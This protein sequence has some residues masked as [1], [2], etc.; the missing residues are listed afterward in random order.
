MKKND[1]TR[2]MVTYMLTFAMAISV[3]PVNSFPSMAAEEGIAGK[4]VQAEESIEEREEETTEV[5]VE[6]LE[7]GEDGADNFEEATPGNP[8]PD[9][10]VQEIEEDIELTPTFDT[11][12][13]GVS[14]EGIDFSGCELLIASE[15]TDIFTADTD[16]VSE[17]NGIYLTRYSNPVQTR[18]AYT[19]YYTRAS[20]VEVNGE[21]KVSSEEVVE[22]IGEAEENS[23]EDGDV[24]LEEDHGEA[25]L[26]DINMGTDAFSRINGTAVPDCKGYIALIDSGS[27]ETGAV[28]RA[29]SLIDDNSNDENGHGSE[30]AGVMEDLSSD[31]DI[32]SI[33]VLDSAGRGSVSDVYA[34]IMYAISA[35]VSVINLSMSSIVTSESEILESAI[36][37]AVSKGII[38]VCSAGNSGKDAKYYMPANIEKAY[39]IGACDID[40]NILPESN[41]GDIVDYYVVGSSTSMSAARF[42]VLIL[43]GIEEAEKS[44]LVFKNKN[45]LIGLEIEDKPEEDQESDWVKIDILSADDYTKVPGY[46]VWI[47]RN[48]DENR[49]TW[50]I[51]FDGGATVGGRAYCVDPDRSAPKIS[52]SS[53]FNSVP[54]SESIGRIL[55]WMYT[56][57]PSDIANF[58]RGYSVDETLWSVRYA[59]HSWGPAYYLES[60][61]DSVKA[62]SYHAVP[63]SD[64][65]LKKWTDDEWA[66]GGPTST[67]AVMVDYGTTPVT[68]NPVT[69]DYRTADPDYYT[70]R[71]L[72]HAP[73]SLWFEGGGSKISSWGASQANWSWDNSIKKYVSKPIMFNGDDAYNF[74]HVKVPSGCTYKITDVKGMSYIYGENETAVI[75]PS[76]II[77]ITA[78]AGFSESFT[79]KGREYTYWAYGVTAGTDQRLVYLYGW[80]PTSI[81]FSWSVPEKPK[82]YVSVRKVDSAE[83]SLAGCTFSLYAQKG[84]EIKDI[85]SGVSRAEDGMVVFSNGRYYYDVTDYKD[86][87]YTIY[88]K[89]TVAAPGY[90]LNDTPIKLEPVETQDPATYLKNSPSI[91]AYNDYAKIY[92]KKSSSNEECSDGN[93]NYSLVGTEFKVYKDS[94]YTQEVC[95]L[96]VRSNET[97]MSD[98]ENISSS[99]DKDSST[100]R[101][102]DTTF[103]YKETAKGKNYVGKMVTGSITVRPNTTGVIGAENTPLMDPTGISVYKTDELGTLLPMGDSTLEGAEF[104]V[105]FYAQDLEKPFDETKEPDR[106]WVLETKKYR[107]GEYYI[108]FRYMDRHL[109]SGSEFYRDEDFMIKLPLGFIK[110]QETKAPE[111]YK[112][113]GKFEGRGVNGENIVSNKDNAIILKVAPGGLVTTGNILV[114]EG[115]GLNKEDQPVRA[116]IELWKVDET[117]EPLS[118]V[119]FKLTEKSTGQSVILV[120]D[121]DGYISTSKDHVSHFTDTNGGTAESGTWFGDMEHIS[122]DYGALM[123]GTYTIKELRCEANAGKQLEE[124]REFTIDARYDGKVVTI[125]DETATSSDGQIWNMVKPEIK[126]TAKVVE[127]D[128]QTLAQEGSDID[129][130]DQT[131]ED[132]I[133][134][135]KLRARSTEYTILTELMVVDKDG[136]Y[137]F[138]KKDGKEYRQITPLVTPEEY[139]KSLYEV[140]D[141]IT[142]TIPHVDPTGLEEEQKKLVVF[143]SLFLGKYESIEEL[144]E[145][146]S[147]GNI[148][149]RYP[150]YDED[151]DMDFFPVEHKDVDDDFQTVRAA[152]IH[153]TIKDSVSRDR[154]AMPKETTITDRVYYTGL[155]VG[156][157]YTVS[158]RLV[159]KEGSDWTNIRYAPDDPQADAEGFV[160][161]LSDK[162]ETEAQNGS[163]TAYTG[164]KMDEETDDTSGGIGKAYFLKDKN[165]EY[166]T[167]SKSFKADSS[168]GYIDIEFT[169]DASLLGGKSTVAFESLSY[170]GLILAVHNDLLDED[171]T[172]H[173]PMIQTVSRNGEIE[174]SEIEK[175]EDDKKLL[176]EVNASSDSK[177]IDEVY[178]ENL[179][180]GR[181]YKLEAV[182]MDKTTG[183]EM[184]D[185]S[186][187]VI[188]AEKIFETDKVGEIIKNRAPDAVSYKLSN[189]VYMDMSPDHA[190]YM[191]KGSADVLFEGYDFTNLSGQTGVVFE[192]V[193]LLREDTDNLYDDKGNRLSTE[194]EKVLV[195]EHKDIADVDQFIYYVSIGTN[196]KDLVTNSKVVPH[197]T[198][199]VIED[200]VT[201]KNVIPGKKYTLTAELI[202]K[203]DRTRKYKDGDKLLDKDG[204]IVKVT[205]DFIPET[206]DGET[207]VKIPVNTAPYR[208]MEIVVFESM[209]NEYGLEVAIHRDLLDEGQ[210]IYVPGGGTKAIDRATGDEVASNG[211]INILDTISYHN[212]EPG[213]E[214]TAKGTLYCRETG[215]PLLDHQNKEISNTVKFTPLEKDGTVEV[216][217][218]IDASLLMGKTIVVS[219]A[220]SHNGITVFI[221]HDLEDSDQSVYIPEIGTTATAPDGSK[222][223]KAS[224]KTVIIDKVHYSNLVVGREYHIKGYL[225]D[226]STGGKLIINGENVVAEKVFTAEATEGD[227]ELEFTFDSTGLSTETVVFEYMYHNEVEVASHTDLSDKGQTVTIIPPNA[228]PK[229]G[230]AVFFILLGLMAA[231]GIGMLLSKKLDK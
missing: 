23:E 167:A 150:V 27:A 81:S 50:N 200:T 221:H 40:G 90:Q 16:V 149:T 169:V 75:W 9:N 195:A 173:Y 151:D 31:I 3:V 225:Y 133:S 207:V 131:I 144:D 15:D 70:V 96:T 171:E 111:G 212:L 89:E 60:D 186:G 124:E 1:K 62:A 209:V 218:K 163:E 143:E 43:D 224:K 216:E 32:L 121:E 102:K 35:N 66:L 118:G 119:K 215:K 33:K 148:I 113:S 187:R 158:G 94:G 227:I 177:F 99:M 97:G 214:Y 203:N 135:E 160:T 165:G 180:A 204:N 64:T 83:K 48:T 159:V 87:G 11:Q 57:L 157:T 18:N 193:Y 86:D 190:N 153:T 140:T 19:Y 164:P 80:K 192:E 110:I 34:G 107:E 78:P 161:V 21:V 54:V 137:E 223:V 46:N 206:S 198:D 129:Y 141:E 211:K 52:Q 181:T 202:V 155:T 128:S 5:A 25:D 101:M 88:A 213:K 29:V 17:C 14:I 44:P 134:Y 170:N 106:S 28:K 12:Y 26:S 20:L 82:Y 172:V 130:K 117:D 154:V 95:T 231:G 174:K 56:G 222:S 123:F 92:L 189:G 220:I 85:I 147:S 59:W 42:S 230:M 100:G 22:T 188:K 8:T 156:N 152:D 146:V 68:A 201:Y 67:K 84:A 109:V 125:Y 108:D 229:T 41:H 194:M 132:T 39:T 38:V 210:T 219:E 71:L 13:E 114:D 24:P 104:T 51:S 77:T 208:D 53:E 228:P 139:Q 10:M 37:E 2:R 191:S 65:S 61:W 182:L 47:E 72:Q 55:Y 91:T 6:D 126:T 116:D 184:V 179:L 63:Y 4:S 69:T 217:F 58:N 145:A 120:T 76:D 199:T 79:T 30:M 49:S 178:F 166:V 142:I 7:V 93:P 162:N 138:Y 73:G 176:K 98:I 183:K 74:I 136:T 36:D 175:A 197:N 45:D 127:T 226:K 185:A 196:A 105:S 168:E 122:D 103:Y 115:R 112:I 205:Y